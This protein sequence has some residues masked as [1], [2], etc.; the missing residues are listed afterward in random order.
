ME[1]EEEVEA[2]KKM[3]EEEEVDA[4]KKMVH[5]ADYLA[6]ICTW[7]TLGTQLSRCSPQLRTLGTSPSFPPLL[8]WA[9]ELDLPFW[10]RPQMQPRACCCLVPA[11]RPCSCLLPA[12]VLLPHA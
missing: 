7:E 10:A 12:A 1:E 4:K 8:L 9:S 6:T 11:A 3:E 2:K 5:L